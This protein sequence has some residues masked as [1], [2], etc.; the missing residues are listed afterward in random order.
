M[1]NADYL[2]FALYLSCRGNAHMLSN[3]KMP[4]EQQLALVNLGRALL[5]R[6]H[7]C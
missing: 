2:F 1:C 4:T 7:G 3:S 5:R 6:C